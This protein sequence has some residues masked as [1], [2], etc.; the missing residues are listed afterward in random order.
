[1]R[2]FASIFYSCV[3]FPKAPDNK[4][5]AILNFFKNSGPSVHPKFSSFK[6]FLYSAIRSG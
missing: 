2:F 6:G 3:I 1:M 5:R 4:N